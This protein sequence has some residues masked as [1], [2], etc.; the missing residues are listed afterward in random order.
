MR[1]FA[2]PYIVRAKPSELQASMP[3]IETELPKTGAERYLLYSWWVA[4]SR[5]GGY[6]VTRLGDMLACCTISTGLVDT[7]VCHAK[8]HSKYD[9]HAST[10]CTTAL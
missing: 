5:F 1:R 8:W 10:A 6:C 7:G 2:N 3:T 4:D 9:E